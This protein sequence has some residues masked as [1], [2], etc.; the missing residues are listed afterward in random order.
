MQSKKPNKNQLSFLSP[1]LREQ[2]NSKQE[3]YLLSEQ[4]N[5]DLF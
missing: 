4:I 2:L 5:W 3:L 1:T